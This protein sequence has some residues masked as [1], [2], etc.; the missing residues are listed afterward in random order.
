MPLLWTEASEATEPS[1]FFKPT[2]PLMQIADLRSRLQ[3]CLE[4]RVEGLGLEAKA[5][6]VEYVINADAGC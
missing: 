4:R 6:R 2:V 5:L 1:Q 3:E